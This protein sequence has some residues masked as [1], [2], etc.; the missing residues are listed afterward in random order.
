[1][2]HGQSRTGLYRI[3]GGM[4]DRCTHTGRPYSKHY[5]DRGIAVCSRW[6]NG[7][8]GL[9]GFECFAHD[10]GQRP[11]PDHS[12]DRIDNDGNY[13]PS[14]CRWATRS[15]QQRNKRKKA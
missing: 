5:V 6:R 9:T 15:Q 8:G 1:M 2:K 13:E 3:W 12:I 4:I 11:S 7:E 14:N 10:M